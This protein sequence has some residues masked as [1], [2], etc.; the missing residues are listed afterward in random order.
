MA[1]WLVALTAEAHAALQGKQ[2]VIERFPF[3]VG[4]ESRL[5]RD[6]SW[7]GG[8]RR[9]GAAPQLNDL[10]LVESGEVLNVSREHF[11]IEQASGR[12]FLVD[13]NSA[14]GTIVE[15]ERVGGERA[16]G[17]VELHDHDVVIVGTS[18]SPFVF[19]FRAG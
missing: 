8:E 5:G 3:K 6:R 10:Y 14:C 18:L 2:H 1:A 7:Q 4:R 15:G 9:A 17:R 19:K 13:R 11:L 12:Y 16:G